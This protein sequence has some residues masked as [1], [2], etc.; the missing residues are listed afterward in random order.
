LSSVHQSSDRLSYDRTSGPVVRPVFANQRD[1][2]QDDKQEVSGKNGDKEKDRDVANDQDKDK[3]GDASKKDDKSDG[4]KPSVRQAENGPLT[5]APLTVA[6]T[7]VA[8]VGTR[9]LPKNATVG[10]MSDAIRLPTGMTRSTP[11]VPYV[12]LWEAAPICHQPLYF[13]DSMLE[14]HGHERFP[15]LQPVA[16]GVR[17]FGTVPV[18]PYLMTLHPPK[19]NLY[20]LGHYPVGTAAPCL[21]ERPP[22]DE[23]ALKVQAL[24]TTAA[25]VGLPN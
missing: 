15:C 5:M 23:H 17:F 9:V 3:K 10:R 11:F 18:L 21:R 2:G 4:K 1:N 22:Y 25:V 7:S 20:N 19:E 14:R 13:Q 6:N 8:D 12:K 16:S 24:T